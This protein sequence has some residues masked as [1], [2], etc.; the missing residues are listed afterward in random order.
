LDEA[1]AGLMG[2]KDLSKAHSCLGLGMVGEPLVSSIGEGAGPGEIES[3]PKVPVSSPIRQWSS[4]FKEQISEG[5]RLCYVEP[6]RI[7][8]KVVVKL[9]QAAVIA[10]I[11][12][13][14]KS[15]VGQF[16]TKAPPFIVVKRFVEGLWSQ[17]GP[18]EVFSTDNGLFLLRFD[19]LEACDKILESRIW[20]VA[21][22]PLI[23]RKW[24]PG[25]QLLDL[26]LQKIP[27]WVKIMRLPVE[28]WNL[29]C[30]GHIA[31]GVG[32]PLYADSTTETNRR[33]GFARVFIEVDDGEFPTEIEVDMG[34]GKAFIVGIEYPWVPVKCPKCHLFGHTGLNCGN[35]EAGHQGQLIRKQWI[36]KK[37]KENVL[38]DPHREVKPTAII[39]SALPNAPKHG[40]KAKAAL[41]RSGVQEI[42][43]KSPKSC[44]QFATLSD[45][46]NLEEET[47]TPLRRNFSNLSVQQIIEEAL[48]CST[49]VRVNTGSKGLRDGV[50]GYV[51]EGSC[52]C[53]NYAS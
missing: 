2:D 38:K 6:K 21:N 47:H 18:V 51:G 44:N 32:Q 41:G 15:L 46:P 36:P 4:L 10:G 52:V 40:G 43:G 23:L 27:I 5:T 26:A 9:P 16:L 53:P 25:L 34:D 50:G 14:E 17:F 7:G 39:G 24:T 20:H 3:L 37:N 49:Q 29:I 19:E 30:L 12:K 31:S 8:S 33:L 22:K 11:A 13:W 28:Y 48:K 42:K 45:E 35:S 1:D